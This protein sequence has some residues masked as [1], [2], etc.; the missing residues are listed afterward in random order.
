MNG[1]KRERKSENMKEGRTG[2]KE[3]KKERKKEGTAFRG[4]TDSGNLHSIGLRHS[5]EKPSLEL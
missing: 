4:K 2:I 1:L 3:R 5:L